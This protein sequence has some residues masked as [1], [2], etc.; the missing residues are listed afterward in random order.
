MTL[1]LY[2]TAAVLMVLFDLGHSAIFP[3]SDPAWGVDIPIAFTTAIT[4]CLVVAAWLSRD[5][6]A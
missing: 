1:A 6:G 3:W 4:A 5:E 2:L